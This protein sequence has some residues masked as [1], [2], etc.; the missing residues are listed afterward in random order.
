MGFESKNTVTQ[1]IQAYCKYILKNKEKFITSDTCKEA[2]K[3]LI[4]FGLFK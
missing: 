3:N 1:D 2:D 4:K